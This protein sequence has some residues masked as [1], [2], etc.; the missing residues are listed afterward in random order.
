MVSSASEKLPKFFWRNIDAP[1]LCIQFSAIHISFYFLSPTFSY[2][3][4]AF[5]RSKF[6]I[7]ASNFGGKIFLAFTRTPTH[8]FVTSIYVEFH[9]EDSHVLQFYMGP[10]VRTPDSE[11]AT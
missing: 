4:I 5:K 3:S 10:S 11:N 6:K 7:R 9:P 2:Y 1:T 8:R